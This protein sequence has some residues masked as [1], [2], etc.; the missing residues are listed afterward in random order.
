[1]RTVCQNCWRERDNDKFLCDKCSQQFLNDLQYIAAYTD[2]L[3]NY[4][5]NR[6]F[7]HQ[8]DPVGAHTQAV[9]PPEPI[10]HS[11]FMLLY[12]D[13]GI[14]ITVRAFA[15]NLA[16]RK[17][18]RDMSIAQTA[19]TILTERVNVAEGKPERKCL[20]DL[21]TPL[22]AKQIHHLVERMRIFLEPEETESVIVGPCPN[23]KC[24]ISLAMRPHDTTVECPRCHSTWAVSF[25]KAE[26]QQRILASAYTGT[27]RDL[28]SMLQ[29]CGV[30]VNASTMRNWVARGKL[31]PVNDDGKPVYKMA[32]AYMLAEN[33]TPKTEPNLWDKID[34][35]QNAAQ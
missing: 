8:P 22:Y 34:G 10:R 16:L 20:Y 7:G 27:Q 31:K 11:V 18:T 32:D 4:K 26:R 23:K 12:D 2:E 33:I 15:T 17:K 1:M 14:E 24:G 19:K 28:R 9:I 21:T 6:A 29:Q 13:D 35:R 5:V 30:N 25:L 3:E